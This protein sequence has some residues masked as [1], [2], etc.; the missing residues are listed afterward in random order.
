MRLICLSLLFSNCAFAETLYSLSCYKSD[1]STIQ[2]ILNGGQNVQT[3]KPVYTKY[4]P[5]RDRGAMLKNEHHS[6][7]R[8]V[9]DVMLS[10]DERSALFVRPEIHRGFGTL[11]RLAPIAVQTSED[12]VVVS[13]LQLSE[14]TES[15]QESVILDAQFI[16]HVNPSEQ[17]DD[18]KKN[19]QYLQFDEKWNLK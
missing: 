5:L 19:Y 9:H 4:V 15:E 14:L 16:S 8:F 18:L 13:H 10:V 7:L 17:S 3:L 2:R 6:D 12:K 11:C 1:S